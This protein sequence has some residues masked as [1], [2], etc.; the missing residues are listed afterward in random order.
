MFTLP[1]LPYPTNALEPYLDTQTL[2]IHFGK[3]HATYLKNLND[4]LPEKSDAD[5]IPVL[6]HLDDLPQDIRVKVRN[7]AGG[8]YN[9]NLYWQCMS[10][11]S[12]SPSPR[13]LSSIESGFGTLDAFKEKF[14]Q[15]ALT[16][17]GSGWAWLVKGTKG[18]EIVTTPNQDS[19]VSTGLTPILGLD[20]WEHA[21]YLKYQNRRVEYI[22]AWWN[23]VNWDYVSSLLADR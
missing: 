4:L 14:S 8:V 19:P 1:P 16:H 11:K 2:E 21:Y 5:L 12:K 9:H 6:Q 3:H 7:N 20:V 17:F 18:L 15:A 22:Q 13:L 23:V 10:P